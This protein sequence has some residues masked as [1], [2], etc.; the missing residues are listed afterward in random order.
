M[1][2]EPRYYTNTKYLETIAKT[3]DQSELEK[4]LETAST[5]DG[6]LAIV[7][8]ITN[9]DILIKIVKNHYGWESVRIQAMMNLEDK[10]ILVDIVKD[11]K[12]NLPV[13]VGAATILDDQ[14][15]LE[16]MAL[17]NNSFRGGFEAIWCLTNNEVLMQIIKQTDRKDVRELAINCLTDCEK[18]EV[19]ATGGEEYI[20]KWEEISYPNLSSGP[21]MDSMSEEELEKHRK[22]ETRT[23]D[24][25]KVAQARLK[26]IE[27]HDGINMY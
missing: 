17:K 15:F 25:R 21:W 16:K 20:H 26:E 4:M 9:Q 24:L 18:L 8:K 6:R 1:I 12:Y 5:E 14:N 13:R 10:S 2:P 3:T 19:I 22:R 7:K 27:Q 11:E 23:L